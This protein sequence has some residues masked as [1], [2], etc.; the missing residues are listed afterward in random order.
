[1]R[2]QDF[3]V[4]FAIAELELELVMATETKLKAAIKHSGLSYR[5]IAQALDV[6]PQAIFNA[7]NGVHMPRVDMAAGIAAVIGVSMDEIWGLEPPPA[8]A[9]VTPE[10]PSVRSRHR[11]SRKHT[12]VS[13]A[14]PTLRLIQAR[15]SAPR[16]RPSSAAQLALF[17]AR[18]RAA[19]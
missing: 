9:T 15:R 18:A 13:V 10:T 11:N 3:I 8:G 5:K 6:S 7:A 16:Q 14:A 17:P 2:V 1:M 19:A 12:A 4:T